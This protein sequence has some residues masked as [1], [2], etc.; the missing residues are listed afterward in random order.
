MLTFSLQHTYRFMWS[1]TSFPTGP[2]KA[3]TGVWA[4]VHL[5]ILLHMLFV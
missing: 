3:Y 4:R 5:K 1:P 2:L